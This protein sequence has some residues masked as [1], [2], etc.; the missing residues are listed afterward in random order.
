MADQ[1]EKVLADARN[2]DKLIE[3]AFIDAIEEFARYAVVG[4]PA[5][6]AVTML[7]SW[8]KTFQSLHQKRV[9]VEKA[10]RT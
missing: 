7:G 8:T 10:R 6:E 4:R 9:V 5:R 2:P 3:R 1:I